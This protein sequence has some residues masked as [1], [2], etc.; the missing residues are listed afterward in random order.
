L[1]KTVQVKQAIAATFEDFDLVIE[2]FNKAAVMAVDEVVG[3][4]VE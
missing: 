4:L 3:D 1:E 2:P